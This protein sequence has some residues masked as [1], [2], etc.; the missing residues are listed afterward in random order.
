MIQCRLGFHA[1]Q[2]ARTQIDQHEMIVGSPG[3]NP[4]T[5]HGQARS[6][7]FGVVY[8]LPGVLGKARLERF[9]QTNG[10]GGDDDASAVRPGRPESLR[11]Q[12][13]GKF[14]FA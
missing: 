8:D 11:V 12:S 13:L 6:E 5:E 4:I 3:D 2:A 14:L 9:V 1:G 10:L 7:G